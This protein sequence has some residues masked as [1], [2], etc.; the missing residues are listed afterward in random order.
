MP[1]T[2]FIVITSMEQLA[3]LLKK[4]DEIPLSSDWNVHLEMTALI[5]HFWLIFF[6]FYKSISV[7][8]NIIYWVRFLNVLIQNYLYKW[9]CKENKKNI[10]KQFIVL[11]IYCILLTLYI[12]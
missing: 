7:D 12:N 9:T 4:F 11:T 8:G 2:E 6:F 1:L 3:A 10:I 5:V